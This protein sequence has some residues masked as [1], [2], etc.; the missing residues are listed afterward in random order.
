[1]KKVLFF[2][3]FLV[4]NT[5]LSQNKLSS[6]SPYLKAIKVEK[7]Q[8]S[9]FDF[10]QNALISWDFSNLDINN[11]ELAI[12]V[13]T[14]YDCFNGDQAK[15]FKQEFSVLSKNNFA[16][17]GKTQLMHLEL[18]AKCFKWRLVVKNSDTSVSEWF[19]FTFIK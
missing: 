9:Q 13:V 6:D 3:L 11:T 18:M 14:I 17:K 5:A 19:Y 4:I 2:A 12:D 7:T 1:M 8:D 10:I 15:D 16:L